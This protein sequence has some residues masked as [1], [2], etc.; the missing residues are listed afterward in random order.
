[1][2]C[3]GSGVVLDCIDSG[4]LPYS[5]LSKQLLIYKAV[6]TCFS[7]PTPHF[8]SLYWVP[9]DKTVSECIAIFEKV[10]VLKYKGFNC[11]SILKV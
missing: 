9:F 11:F 7:T 1:M 3:P 2:W 6:T 4:Y 8:T 5:F 10:K